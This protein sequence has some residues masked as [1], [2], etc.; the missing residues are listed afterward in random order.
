MLV[1]SLLLNNPDYTE[2][3]PVHLP[4]LCVYICTNNKEGGSL[5]SHRNSTFCHL[6]TFQQILNVSMN[7]ALVYFYHFFLVS[8]C[9]NAT[10]S[11]F[12]YWWA[13]T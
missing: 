5:M 10:L 7:C 13:L 11:V 1:G 9:V 6:A 4:L 8:C 12:P 3:T 2:V